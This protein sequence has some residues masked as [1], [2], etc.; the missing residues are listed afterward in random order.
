MS[1]ES[2]R[3]QAEQ[4]RI[5]AERADE[6]ARRQ[7]IARIASEDALQK[8]QVRDAAAAAEERRN[9]AD[10]YTL[11]A[12][13]RQ[14][15]L[16]ELVRNIPVLNYF[17]QPYTPQRERPN[18]TRN[19][20]RPEWTGL[21]M[22]MAGTQ[23]DR[24]TDAPDVKV[25]AEPPAPSEA[26]RLKAFMAQFGSSGG[27]MAPRINSDQTGGY[28]EQRAATQALTGAL[29]AED[30]NKRLARAG[31]QDLGAKYV[32][33]LG[34]AQKKQQDL[35]DQ[36][37]S[38][39]AEESRAN[40]EAEGSFDS[41]RLTR[42]LGENPIS[43][44]VMSF[45]AGLVGSLKGAAGDTSPNMVLGE[46][47]KAVERD[48]MNQ[49]VQYERM[50][51]GQDS[52]RTN[53]TDE[54]KMGETEQTALLKATTASVD[55]HARALEYAAARI[56]DAQA[57]AKVLIAAGDLRSEYGKLR[58]AADVKK[59]EAANASAS[60]NNALK[61]RFYEAQQALRAKNPELVAEADK[62]YGGL[63]DWDKTLDVSRALASV[64][65]EASQISTADLNA[66]FKKGWFRTLKDTVDG[67]NGRDHGAITT[68]LASALSAALT[69][70]TSPAE[71][72]I[73]RNFA[74]FKNYQ[75]KERHGG[76]VTNME[77]IRS[78][79]GYG[80][81]SPAAFRDMLDR[82]IKSD[83]AHLRT[84]TIRGDSDP[85]LKAMLDASLGDTRTILDGYQRQRVT[86]AALSTA[87]Q[88]T[89]AATAVAGTHESSD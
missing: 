16:R 84:T 27:G 64:V 7:S 50:R 1:I 63:K 38:A 43:S 70:T 69:A 13:F 9:D 60:H 31:I 24:A 75:I 10:Q 76:N 87:A 62:K 80:M 45:A 30:E 23:H 67:L 89:T 54:M 82:E 83:L 88:P 79:A 19:E 65:K 68:G 15:P 18:L 85:Y 44:A 6:E 46:V 53:F 71:Q 42:K 22:Y 29:G 86:E 3:L 25:P 40:K 73:I 39:I 4:L 52:A 74:A 36:R 57:K 2:E 41:M 11:G 21:P 20:T 8:K 58:W 28:L 32:T 47:D 56:G 5:A 14:E 66:A 34:L 61:L 77:Q 72:A 12:R 33:D 35:I 48:V 26:D 78:D 37:K 49:K 17:S 81:S 51:N 55:Q 59:A